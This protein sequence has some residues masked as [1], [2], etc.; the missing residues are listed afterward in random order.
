MTPTVQP[1]VTGVTPVTGGTNR[2]FRCAHPAPPPTAP[3]PTID[4]RRRTGTRASERASRVAT[5]LAVSGVVLVRYWTSRPRRIF[6]IT[7]DE[8]GQLAIARFIGR[9]ARWNM[10]DHS[11]WRPA[12]GSLISPATWFSD[13]PETVFRTALAVNAVLGGAACWLLVLLAARLTPLSRPRCAVV[14]AVVSLAPALVFTTNWVWSES[15]VQITF[16]AFLSGAL[17]FVA[18]PS[19]R[20]GLV[21][22]SAATL[23]FATHSRLLPLAGLATLF[24]LG[25]MARRALRRPQGAFLLALIGASMLG[26]SRFSAYVVDRLWDDPAPTNTATEMLDRLDSFRALSISAV[27]QIWYQLVA[28]AGVAG[29]GVLTLARRTVARR[30]TA[31]RLGPPPGGRRPTSADAQV[32]LVVVA[33]IVVVSILFMTDR[34]RPDQMVYGRYND[35]AMAPILVVGAAAL[36]TANARR[37]IVDGTI[38]IGA[39]VGTGLVLSATRQR[40]LRAGGMVRSMVLGLLAH[41]GDGTVEVLSTT[42]VAAALAAVISLLALGVGARARAPTLVVAAALLVSAGYARTRPVVDAGLNTWA[43]AAAV[44][45]VRGTLLPAGEM[46]RD[47]IGTSS[48]VSTGEQ[49]L[50]AK[51]YQFY[52]PANALYLDGDL[53]GGVWTPYVF[54]PLDDRTLVDAGATV[55]WRDPTVA[56]GLWVEPAPLT[57]D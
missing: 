41:V 49:R 22:V 52:L 32:V 39:L 17:A 19:M 30:R 2:T 55:V 24:V 16:L 36:V 10:F 13:D 20:R 12:F 28:T 27:G 54:A 47:R 44:E 35:A 14:A 11:T 51:L 40:D 29:F 23:G 7:P 38:V 56:I 37:L 9:G 26:V 53:P 42:F 34:S 3:A 21:V 46:V 1:N 18:A 15:L 43:D 33:S 50:R 25:A 6:H 5:A 4:E 8:P 31:D 57:N 48:R 45:E